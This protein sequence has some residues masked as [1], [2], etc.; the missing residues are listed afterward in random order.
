MVANEKRERNSIDYFS[1]FLHVCD[2]FCRCIESLLEDGDKCRI[3]VLSENNSF[4]GDD[5]LILVSFIIG[6]EC[7]KCGYDVCR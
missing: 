2:L 1:L 5:V 3:T 4:N 6:I 7:G